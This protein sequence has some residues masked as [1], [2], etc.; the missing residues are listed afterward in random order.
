MTSQHDEL[1]RALGV[2][3]REEADSTPVDTAAAV[4]RLDRVLSSSV[5]THRFIAIS[6]TVAAVVIA[7]LGV[8]LGG[9]VDDQSTPPPSDKLSPLP[10]VKSSLRPYLLDITTG[11]RQPLAR[12]LVPESVGRMTGHDDFHFEVSPDGERLAY[13]CHG[14]DAGC[15]RRDAI[16]VA[17]IDGTDIRTLRLPPEP[18]S[19]SDRLD[20]SPDGTMLAYTVHMHGAPTSGG[21]FVQDIATGHKR[22]L[23]DFYDDFSVNIAFTPAHFSTD[24]QNVLFHVP[25]GG[26]QSAC[27]V[28]QVP[29]K[30][31]QPTMVLSDAAF[32]MPLPAGDGLAFLECPADSS[33]TIQVVDDQ[34]ERRTLVEASVSIARPA[35]SPDGGTI[36]YQDGRFIRLV[37][38]ETGDSARL[39]RGSYSVSWVDGDTLLLAPYLCC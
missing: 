19:T 25:R 8:A 14:Y 31:G 16:V 27:D 6:A 28:W 12:S 21:L 9:G 22:Q 30:G 18:A 36:A 5:H 38:V 7:V 37:E 10:P 3:L 2:M 34:G 17:D 32:P 4:P 39:I 29:V 11:E 24:G 15:L 26:W 35:L 13:V 23:V 20:W 1:R 33:P